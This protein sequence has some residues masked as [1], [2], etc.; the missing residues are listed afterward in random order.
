MNGHTILIVDDDKALSTL[1]KDCLAK[2]HIAADLAYDGMVG[3]EKAV[4]TDYQVIV[5]DV[6]LPELNGFEVLAALRRHT[7]TPVLMLTAKDDEIDKVT[8]LRMGADDYMTKP[9]SINEFLARIQSLIRRYTIFN[10]EKEPSANV[11]V[12]GSLCIDGTCRKVSI[13]NHILDLTSKE[14]DILYLLAAG[15]GRVFTKKQIY[16]AVWQ[17]EFAFDDSNIMS[18]MSKLRKKL[19]DSGVDWECI[20]TVWGVGYRFN[21]GEAL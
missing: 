8:G 1:L 11:L 15:S 3:L 2:E 19:A 12:F 10:C 21:S 20:Q 13:H 4:H 7:Q 5:L 16:N 9:F 14:F 17:D 18:Y 6:M